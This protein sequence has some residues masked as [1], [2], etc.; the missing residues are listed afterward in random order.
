[1]ADIPSAIKKTAVPA[2]LR[3]SVGR[4]LCALFFLLTYHWSYIDFTHPLFEYGHYYYYPRE[5]WV[6]CLA[7]ALALLPL[8]GYKKSN[9]P[10]QFGVAILYALCY[11]PAIL[12]ILFMWRKP[13]WEM[14]LLMSALATSMWVLFVFSRAGLHPLGKTI[15]AWRKKMALHNGGIQHKQQIRPTQN[16]DPIVLTNTDTVHKRKTLSMSDA[17]QDPPSRHTWH[18]LS[19]PVQQT[20]HLLTAISLVVL[21]VG[22]WAHM[23]LVG[24]EDVYELRFDARDADAG[25]L[26]GYLVMWLSMCFTPYYATVG[27][28]QKNRRYFWSSVIFG[29]LIYMSNGAKSA[30]MLPA[31]ILILSHVYK[32]GTDFLTRILLLLG[33]LVGGLTAL[34]WPSLFMAKSVLFVRTLST[35]GWTL[36][37]YYEYFTTYGYS[38]FAHIG[39]IN[40]LTQAYPYGNLGLGQVIGLYYSGSTDAN[41]NANFWASDGV[42]AIGLWGILPATLAMVLV[43][44]WINKSAR[45]TDLRLVAMWLTGFWLA[46]L[47]APISTSLLSGGGIWVLIFLW[48]SK[49]TQRKNGLKKHSVLFKQQKETQRKQPFLHHPSQTPI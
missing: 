40:Y 11:A 18:N 36:T 37:T 20:I 10:A 38:Y 29:L 45:G 4:W 22:N 43:L 1:M 28:L 23:R 8:L 21:I 7:Y 5:L 34:E 9:A 3:L 48:F 35:G 13:Q 19:T 26:Q 25:A 31:I 27:A 2:L 46:L 32:P 14:L 44:Y 33:L 47:N 17:G 6:H 24:F 49:R 41:F 39:I 30:L 16:H 42:A 15:R 12:T